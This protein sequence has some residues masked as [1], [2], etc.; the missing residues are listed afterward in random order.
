MGITHNR[1]VSSGDTGLAD[2]WNA[3]HEITDDLRPKSSNTVIVAAWNSIDKTRAD[4][5]CDS[6]D[7]DIEIQAAIDSLPEQGGTIY[8]KEGDYDISDSLHINKKNV[9]FCG[10]GLSTHIQS[11]INAAFIIIDASN[12]YSVIQDM[13][14]E[15]NIPGSNTYGIYNPSS[16]S[17]ISIYRINLRSL[18]NKVF[19]QGIYI[20]SD[21]T[22]IVRDCLLES[23]GD[24]AIYSCGKLIAQ[25]NTI[26]QAGMSGISIQKPECIITSN[27]I[28]GSNYHGI[29]I[30]GSNSA[31][32][33]SVIIS[34]NIFSE[35]GLDGVHSF[36]NRTYGLRRSLISNNCFYWMTNGVSLGAK[37]EHT[38][39]HG[40]VFTGCSTDVDDNGSNNLITDNIAS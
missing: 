21:N 30:L 5:V 10:A 40:N 14:L 36:D 39:V 7:D 38:L 3:E 34:N 20:L 23:I 25:G 28:F 1:V 2:D 12:K 4:F 19:K 35:I 11:S 18:A 17:K 26:F 29:S 9:I 27:N 24:T 33:H 8:L 16:S 32:I 31:V 22:L 37:T 13:S 15:S 6:I